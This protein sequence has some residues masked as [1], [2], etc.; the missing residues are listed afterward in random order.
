MVYS[1]LFSKMAFK[2]AILYFTL[3]ITS[4]VCYKPVVLIHGVMTGS[5][6]M[7]IIKLRIQEVSLFANSEM[8]FE[9]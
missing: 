7:D 4:I 5:A 3:Y 9:L 6:S 2:I 8:M 1:P